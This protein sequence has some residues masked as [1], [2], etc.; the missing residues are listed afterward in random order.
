[1]PG[2]MCPW[3]SQEA[4]CA[5]APQGNKPATRRS[6]YT[7]GLPTDPH[8][9][10]GGEQA[11]PLLG[12]TRGPFP[13]SATILCSAHCRRHHSA[14][15]ARIA[16]SMVQQAGSEAAP[17]ASAPQPNSTSARRREPQ[18]SLAATGVSRAP[19]SVA[20]GGRDGPS[21]GQPPRAG[22]GSVTI[23]HAAAGRPAGSE[24][25]CHLHLAVR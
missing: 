8:Q 16:T 19:A 20:I 1:M 13:A 3:L 24:S 9:A 4:R 11:R 6:R 17:A 25:A 21:Q 5:P 18:H 14:R 23:S 10:K 22:T 7:A 12:R 2:P 15:G